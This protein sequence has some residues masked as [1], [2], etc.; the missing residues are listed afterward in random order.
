LI[1]IVMKRAKELNK[2]MTFEQARDFAARQFP[3]AK[4]VPMISD[5]NM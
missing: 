1:A 3:K 2:P 4:E 5:A